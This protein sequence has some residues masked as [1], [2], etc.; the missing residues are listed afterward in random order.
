MTHKVAI[1][2]CCEVY[3]EN[4]TELVAQSITDW[5]EIS[6]E[7]FLLLK[8]A[9]S[10]FHFVVIEQP[11]N[12]G[13]FIA[14]TIADYKKLARREK[15]KKEAEARKR[16]QAALERKHRKELKLAGSKKA[17]FEQLKKEFGE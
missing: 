7:D 9:Q 11:N 6:H 12:T 2:K 15:E 3:T 1:L 4:S 5:E 10:Q 13:E 8:A 17:L 14:K 16:E